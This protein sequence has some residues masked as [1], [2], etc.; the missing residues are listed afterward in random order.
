MRP[1]SF[2]EI[3]SHIKIHIYKCTLLHFVLHVHSLTELELQCPF[4]QLGCHGNI[5]HAIIYAKICNI[6]Y[7]ILLL[8]VILLFFLEGYVILYLS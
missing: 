7:S 2:D 3:F 4:T 8:K 6:S 1:N 5:A